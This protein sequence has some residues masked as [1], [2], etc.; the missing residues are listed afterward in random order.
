MLSYRS[1]L[2]FVISFWIGIP[3]A[4]ATE[5]ESLP[6]VQKVYALMQK[7]GPVDALKEEVL[8]DPAPWI[9]RAYSYSRWKKNIYL[10]GVLPKLFEAELETLTPSTVTSDVIATHI[11][12]VKELAQVSDEFSVQA[13]VLLKQLVEKFFAPEGVLRGEDL[14]SLIS[15][16]PD[17]KKLPFKNLQRLEAIYSL[18]EKHLPEEK[19]M[20]RFFYAWWG[21]IYA[22]MGMCT[23]GG[24]KDIE[25]YRELQFEKIETAKKIAG[26]L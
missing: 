5:Y 25:Y 19:L 21:E 7:M 26:L 18:L 23:P 3:W 17:E 24:V 22:N 1:L 6:G 11:K 12:S 20:Q 4:F 16:S 9:T 10:L 2:I 15:K 14:R 13:P 8:L